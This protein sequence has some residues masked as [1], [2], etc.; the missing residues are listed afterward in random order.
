MKKKGKKFPDLTGPKGKK[1]GKVTQ[2]DILAGRGVIPKADEWF[3]DEVMSRVEENILLEE[4]FFEILEG[5]EEE[6]YDVESLTEEDLNEF[7]NALR[8][9]LKKHAGLDFFTAK[10]DRA[11]RARKVGE[12][13]FA[14]NAAAKRKRDTA[15]ANAPILARMR[16]K[17]AEPK[18]TAVKTLAAK[19]K[20]KKTTGS[21]TEERASGGQ[22]TRAAMRKRVALKKDDGSR[23]L[24][25]TSDNTDIVLGARLAL[26]E[27]I[28]QQLTK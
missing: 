25:A 27:R 16:Q 18:D 11:E 13:R 5:L 12:K 7:F 10:E 20:K 24:P 1:D 2:A 4:E 3:V 6:G 14:A 17:E 15:K 8:R 21:G 28:L 22:L 9:G 19:P 26:A 23:H